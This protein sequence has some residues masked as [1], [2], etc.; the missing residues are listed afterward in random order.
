MSYSV[1]FLARAQRELL[2]A[3][4]W[5]E[6]RQAGLGDRFRNKVMERIHNITQ[7]P[8]RYPLRNKGFREVL[9]EVFPYLVI[10]RIDKN[11]NTIAIASIFHTSQNPKRKYKG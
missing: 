2:E 11:K 4:E 5:Y 3:W 10:Y 7:H 8:E 1:I 6:D 9:I